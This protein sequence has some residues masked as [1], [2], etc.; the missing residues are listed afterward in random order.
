M[1]ATDLYDAGFKQLVCVVP[2][3]AELS[4]TTSIKP[5]MRG[6]C[7]GVRKRDGKW[8]GYDFLHAEYP[9]QKEVGLWQDEDGA[10]IGILAENFPGLDID[11][12]DYNL[13]RF[14]MQEAREVLGDAP[15]R[16][17]REPRRL[18]VYRTAV[19]FAR[20]ACRIQYRG[21]EH[22][23]EML[24]KGRQYLVAGKHPSGS[25]Y[26]WEDGDLA[27]WKPHELAEVT[28]EQVL[29]FF[30]HIKERLGGRATVVIEGTGSTS[31]ERAPVQDH[32]MGPDIRSLAEVVSKIPNNYADRDG[33]IQVG[34]AIKAASM[35]ESG[36]GFQVF[37]D[38]ALTWEG[39]VNEI[40]TVEADWRRM[41]AP[42]RVG[43]SY[44]QELAAEASDYA[45]AGDEFVAVKDAGTPPPPPLA[46]DNLSDLWAVRRLAE[47]S[48]SSLRYVPE[49][50]H[51]HIWN[52]HAW[53]Q[54]RKNEAKNIIWE[55]MDAI[56]ETIDERARAAPD[57]EGKPLF[58]FAAAL[59]SHAMLTRVMAGIQAHPQMTLTLDEFDSDL[60]TLNTPG[61]IVDLRTGKLGPSDAAALMSKSTKA[62]PSAKPPERWLRF[63][64]E[65]TGGDRDLQLFLQ[66]QIG[67]ALTGVT[68]EQT[69]A[70]IHGPPFTGKSVF[71]ETVGGMLG[72]YHQTAAAETFSTSKGSRHPTDLAKL[73]G[74]RLV[75]ASETEEGRAW[76]T[77]RI[78]AI[79]GGDTI[80]ARFMR[81]DFFEYKPTY[82]VVIVGNHE[83]E[84][85][86][87]DDAMMRRIHIVP[88][89]HT[90]EV[91]DKL[92]GETLKGEYG[93]ILAWAIEGCRLW[94]VED[95][96]P[97][98]VVL[99][100]T[101]D[102]K[103]EEDPIGQFIEDA[104]DLSDR[105]ATVTNEAL[106]EA[107]KRW[108][109]RHG[110]DP[111]SSK[112]FIRQ[113]RNKQIPLGLSKTRIS[114]TD[115]RRAIKGIQLQSEVEAWQTTAT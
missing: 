90:P 113:F 68:Q 86:G 61:G 18:L 93:G 77:Q 69:L 11:C 17:S 84:I 6:K 82:K 1:R 115:R 31:D 106:F 4:P 88:F 71:A 16:T 112:R 76:D 74:A 48:N 70:F 13:V 100:R 57:K 29:A 28:P 97:P 72:T 110:E 102:Y 80:N 22:V 30:Q 42:Y 36:A 25:D 96:T 62:A 7:P 34:H 3:D 46:L 47:S 32:L 83:P 40:E 45:P 19:P 27:Q 59:R 53:A 104:C 52:G 67:Y 55:R 108:C 78:K 10:N 41:Q 35:G 91:K 73:A 21:K 75:T 60:W 5:A 14:I 23:V 12:E 79:T 9:S 85:K 89:I 56:A 37:L 8:I 44:L 43:W 63:L 26:G 95:L 81:K 33:Y 39:G 87:V 103:Y 20:I 111:G 51:W 99:R 15:V 64:E 2:P 65:T 101:Q 50:K 92:L 107:W 24:G 109:Y 58:R 38:W 66:K 49:T 94:Q 105:H 54:D 114:A 98:D